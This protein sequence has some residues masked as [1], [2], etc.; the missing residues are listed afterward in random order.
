MPWTT[1]R[2]YFDQGA[3]SATPLADKLDELGFGATAPGR[4]II[5]TPNDLTA[6]FRQRAVPD[7][8]LLREL[9]HNYYT[10]GRAHWSWSASSTNAAAD[11]GLAKGLVNFAACGAFNDNFAYMATRVLGIDGIKKGN[12]AENIGK[13]WYKGNFV[14]MPVDVIDSHWEG[15]VRSHNYAFSALKMFKFTDHYF[16]NYNGVIFDATGNATHQSTKT[17]VAFDLERLQPADAAPYNGLNGEVFRVHNVSE[18]F[19]AKPDLDLR[20]GSWVLVALGPDILIADNKNR[21][22]NRYLLTRQSKVGLSEVENFQ[23]TYG[24]TKKT[25]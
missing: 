22:F 17:L 4:T 15:A 8:A 16:C 3:A 11:G 12:A 10:Y 24:R 19:V 18:N 25:V 20:A 13:T 5:A 21:A 9:M 14:T 2:Q 7:D 23:L 6:R 1:R